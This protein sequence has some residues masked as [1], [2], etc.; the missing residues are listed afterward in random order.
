MVDWL[1]SGSNP[2]AGTVFTFLG[3]VSGIVVYFLVIKKNS[4]RSEITSHQ[5]MVILLCA[6]V[7]G[8]VGAK[9]TQWIYLGWP[10]HTLVSI[11]D[12][13]VGGRTIIGGL[14]TGWIAVEVA[15]WR[16]GIRHSTGLPFALALPAG[17]AVGR[18]GC[19]FNGCCYGIETS[20]ILGIS[21]NGTLRHPTQIYHFVSAILILVALV[22]I[23]PHLKIEGHL[24]RYYLILWGL[25]RFVI[26]FYRVQDQLIFR[27]SLAQWLSLQLVAAGGIMVCWAILCAD[28]QG[29]EINKSQD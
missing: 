17:E 13:G 15:K 12:F 6:V 2:Q 9:L 22:F 23:R 7:A 4:N 27:L 1:S 16:M 14:I 11:T 20:S 10:V 18:I 24:F 3:Y 29:Q 5:R 28:K 8:V 21:H 26:E 25:S 19:W